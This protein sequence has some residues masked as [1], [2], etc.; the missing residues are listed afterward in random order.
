[1][2]SMVVHRVKFCRIG[3]DTA[4]PVDE[5]GARL[6]AVPEGEGGVGELL[7]SRIALRMGTQSAGYKILS[8]QLNFK[9]IVVA[10]A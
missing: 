7:G 9:R 8:L 4:P 6:Y 2:S 3:V 1:M 10:G 5:V